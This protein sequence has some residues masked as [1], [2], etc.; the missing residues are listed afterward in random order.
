MKKSTYNKIIV[1]LAVM[2][3]EC[4]AIIGA[5]PI[6]GTDLSSY[7]HYSFWEANEIVLPAFLLLVTGGTLFYTR[8][9]SITVKISA[10]MLIVGL[11]LFTV[12]ALE[13]LS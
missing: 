10:T 1:A 4:I 11:L 7:F 9:E 5:L 3:L 8:H 2:M 13:A 6:F 12:M